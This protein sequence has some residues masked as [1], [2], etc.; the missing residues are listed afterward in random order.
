VRWIAPIIVLSGAAA[1][2]ASCF[3]YGGD[4]PSEE[5]P[6]RE[7]IDAAAD[8][9]VI[10]VDAPAEKDSAVA[11]VVVDANVGPCD[12]A[13]AFTSVQPIVEVNT[14]EDETA[15]HLST[16]ELTV[17]I[18]RGNALAVYQRGTKTEAFKGG[19]GLNINDGNSNSVRVTDDT[20]RAFFAANLGGGVNAT[21]LV[22]KA[23]PTT[24]DLFADQS[25]RVIAFGTADGLDE[26]DP[27]P[28]PDEKT[29]YFA[30]DRG[31]A[32]K[33]EL[34][35]TRKDAQ[36]AW[37]DPTK[38]GGISGGVAAPAS[39][40]RPVLSADQKAIYFTTF[41]PP[42]TPGKGAIWVGHANAIAKD[43]FTVAAAVGVEAAGFNSHPSWLST[44]SCR[45]YFVSDRAGGKGM[46]DLW[47][48][49]KNP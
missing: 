16:D 13:K 35:V 45:L 18:S 10:G 3:V 17:Y 20:L 24:T 7:E 22:T 2:V 46:G 38:L 4:D 44:D 41:R 27:W 5:L 48:A 47:V 23:R 34:W 39:D 8:V 37:S 30:S 14:P 12:P 49:S 6:P 43:A 33:H 36:G 9:A 25:N 15:A 1:V 26:L 11:D 19:A 29:L 32:G 28:S 31:G 42:A 21:R 40:R